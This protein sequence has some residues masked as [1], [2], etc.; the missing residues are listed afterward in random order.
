MAAPLTELTKGN[1]TF[2]WGE[3]CEEAFQPLKRLISSAPVLSYRRFDRE[4]ILQTDASDVGVGAVL[5]QLDDDGKE[6]PVAFA[7]QSLSA[8]D[9]N[10][11]VTEKEAYG[12]VYAVRHFRVYLLGRQY[13]AQRS[14][15]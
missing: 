13:G 1:K 3:N 10:Y 6:R 8:R 4:F 5:S 9:R 11:S 15:S 12:V 7:S 2:E 14:I